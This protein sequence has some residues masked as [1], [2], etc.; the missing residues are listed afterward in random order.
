MNA[1]GTSLVAA[2]GAG[3]G[4]GARPKDGVTGVTGGPVD[5]SEADDVVGIPAYGLLLASVFAAP[6]PPRNPN[7]G[8]GGAPA[9]VPSPRRDGGGLMLGS[10]ANAPASPSDVGGGSGLGGL[11]PNGELPLVLGSDGGADERY[12]PFPADMAVLAAVNEA[13]GCC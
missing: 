6:A 8:P 2:G 4:A 3:A 5:G 1:G 10:G 9:D 11:K 12:E 13:N 7:A